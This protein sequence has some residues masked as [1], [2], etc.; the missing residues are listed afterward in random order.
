MTNHPNVL[1]AYEVIAD[2]NCYYV[3]T[4]YCPNRTLDDY[5]KQRGRIPE[6]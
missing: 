3:I 4:N 2:A 5:I 6:D 1:K